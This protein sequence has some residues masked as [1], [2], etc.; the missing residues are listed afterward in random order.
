MMP[1]FNLVGSYPSYALNKDFVI[2]NYGPYV[3]QRVYYTLQAPQGCLSRA[4]LAI[5]KAV[6]SD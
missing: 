6:I 1:N 2:L 3:N 4:R 5:S